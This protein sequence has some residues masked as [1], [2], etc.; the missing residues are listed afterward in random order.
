MFSNQMKLS[1]SINFLRSWCPGLPALLPGSHPRGIESD[2]K[3]AALLD[4]IPPLY[5][6][7]EIV[8]F[9]CSEN[10][11]QNKMQICNVSS[12]RENRKLCVSLQEIIGALLIGQYLNI[13]KCKC[14][15]SF[16]TR[17][18]GSFVCPCKNQMLPMGL[19]QN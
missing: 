13:Q 19:N 12:H 16:L 10:R 9:C 18:T 3:F 7:I 2:S 1:D 8:N 5:F 11:H 15:M 6:F 17:K 4:I 14:A